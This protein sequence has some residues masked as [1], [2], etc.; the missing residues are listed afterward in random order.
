MNIDWEL[1]KDGEGNFLYYDHGNQEVRLDKP[2]GDTNG[3]IFSSSS[4]L[5]DFISR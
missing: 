5:Q 3:S 2:S 1:R 4:R